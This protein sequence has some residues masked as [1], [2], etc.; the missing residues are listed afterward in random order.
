[1]N[2]QFRTI[3]HPPSAPG[4]T[5]C[6]PLLALLCFQSYITGLNFL[7]TSNY[8]KMN[9]NQKSICPFEDIEP[10]MK[11]QRSFKVKS[12][13]NLDSPA[14]QKDGQSERRKSLTITS[15][16]RYLSKKLTKRA[17]GK[18]VKMIRIQSTQYRDLR[19]NNSIRSVD[20][21]EEDWATMKRRRSSLSKPVNTV[22]RTVVE[23]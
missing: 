8:Q 14:Y 10:P 12:S 16:G 18:N 11:K 5:N 13:S 3:N 17:T 6:A 4:I 7:V 1:M 23:E 20:F 19:R 21:W 2:G 9:I 15:I 22:K